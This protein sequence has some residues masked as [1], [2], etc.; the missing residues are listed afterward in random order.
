MP[1]LILECSENLAPVLREQKL[2]M[3]VHA[4]MQSSGLFV[5]EDIRSRAYVAQ[6][7]AIGTEATAGSFAHVVIYLMEGRATEQKRALAESVA[8]VLKAVLPNADFL[9]VDVREL[10]PAIYQK[11]KRHSNA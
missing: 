2:L 3:R 9:S 4:A 6:D 10:D 8:E 1:H 5:P 11:H 7:F